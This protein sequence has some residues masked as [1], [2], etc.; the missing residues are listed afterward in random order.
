MAEY[1]KNAELRELILEY[2][3]TNM[4]D[5]GSWLN[6]YKKRM[7]KKFETGKLKKEK[8]DLAINFVNIRIANNAAKFA[9][10][11]SLS[12]E[13]KK[14][15]DLKFK[16]LRDDLWLKFMKIAQGRIASMRF[17]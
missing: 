3:K 11:E 7:T 9:H 6:A 5:D 16:N 13:E 4:E 8:Y 10:Y 12:T 17:A 15:Y 2:N 14:L 1:V